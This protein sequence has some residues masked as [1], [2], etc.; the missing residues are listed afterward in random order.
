[1]YEAK[2]AWLNYVVKR[3]DYL[4][5]KAAF[6]EEAARL[7]ER[8]EAK[9]KLNQKVTRMNKQMKDFDQQKTQLELAVRKTEEKSGKTR[10]EV[11]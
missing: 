2:L 10:E 1:M 11:C 5:A 7:K 8:D 6:R 4:Q 9:T 3:N